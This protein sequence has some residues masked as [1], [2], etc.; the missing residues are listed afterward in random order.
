MGAPVPTQAIKAFSDMDIIPR[1][2]WKVNTG[3]NPSGKQKSSPPPTLAMWG[4]RGFLRKRTGILRNEFHDFFGGH[5][6][7]SVRQMHFYLRN[8][9]RYRPIFSYGIGTKPGIIR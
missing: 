6:F 3:F 4:E 7:H 5:P 9:S 8:S 2:G 1:I